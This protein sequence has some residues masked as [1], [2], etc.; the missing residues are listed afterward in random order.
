MFD[1]V[2]WSTITHLVCPGADRRIAG[3]ITRPTRLHFLH[4]KGRSLS[5]KGTV[6]PSCDLRV[7]MVVKHRAMLHAPSTSAVG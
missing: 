5:G 6:G 2:C 1:L 7:Q 4:H 3:G